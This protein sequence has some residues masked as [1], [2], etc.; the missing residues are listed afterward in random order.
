MNIQAINLKQLYLLR[1]AKSAWDT[2]VASDFQRPLNKRGQRNA[3]GV[4]DWMA[5]QGIYPEHILSSP[6]L[7]AWQTSTLVCTGLGIDEANIHFYPEL[8]LAEI[9]TL[10]SCIKKIPADIQSVLLVGHN[11]GME[12]L[13]EFLTGNSIPLPEDEKLLPTATLACL[14]IPVDWMDLAAD[15]ANLSNLKRPQ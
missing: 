14:N 9:D 10:L 7:R 5:K 15:V 11:P 6:A 13:L 2:D 12:E 8:Y 1:H 4:G 3:K